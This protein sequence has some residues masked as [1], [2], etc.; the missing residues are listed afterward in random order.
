MV[1][2]KTMTGEKLMVSNNRADIDPSWGI[3]FQKQSA[4]EESTMLR[5][6]RVR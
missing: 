2:S 5:E 4:Y 1:E 3:I 6:R